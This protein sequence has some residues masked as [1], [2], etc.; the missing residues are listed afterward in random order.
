[1]N[2]KYLVQLSTF[3]L[4]IVLS[5]SSCT[6]ENRLY[7]E[8][9]HVEFNTG[10]NNSNTQSKRSES[11]K[12]A[13]AQYY[14]EIKRSNLVCSNDTQPT[15][16]TNMVKSSNQ[17]DNQAN[18]DV[19]VLKDGE[20]FE[21]KVVE[22]NPKDIKYRSCHG[23]SDSL[24]SI[25]KSSVFLIQ[26]PDGSKDVFKDAELISERQIVENTESAP[27]HSNS[28]DSEP[29]KDNP[30]ISIMSFASAITAQLILLYSGDTGHVLVGI[31]GVA[32]LVLGLVGIIKRQRFFGFSL[33]GVI[34]G[35][36]VVTTL[37][38]LFISFGI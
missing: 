20:E 12:K 6:I 38:L 28:F 32:A 8:G 33:V 5:F 22:V 30:T 35:G 14:S 2:T 25:A 29:Q 19:I 23:T 17:A 11:P 24:L 1:M 4:L 27:N 7:N 34:Y 36:I 3:L 26:Y 31:F 15:P 13:F 37:L 10:K 9:Y 21:C 16:D 18:C